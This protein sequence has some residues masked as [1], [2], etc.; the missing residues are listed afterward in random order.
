MNDEKLLSFGIT[1][2]MVTTGKNHHFE[3]SFTGGSGRYWAVL[4]IHYELDGDANRRCSAQKSSVFRTEREAISE[5]RSWIQ[6]IQ[7]AIH[8]SRSSS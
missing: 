7:V 2:P 1:D 5:A 6:E 4:N 3:P 8:R